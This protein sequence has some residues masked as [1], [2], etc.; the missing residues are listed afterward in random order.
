[1]KHWLIRLGMNPILLGALII[2]VADR[3]N[4]HEFPDNTGVR[5]ALRS[6]QFDD[7]F[8]AAWVVFNATKGIPSPPS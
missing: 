2:L 3:A 7:I 1:M 6:I 8:L 4:A 5:I